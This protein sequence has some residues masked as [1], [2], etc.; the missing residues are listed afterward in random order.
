[1]DFFT[2]LSDYYLFGNGAREADSDDL[3]VLFDL[4]ADVYGRKSD[5]DLEDH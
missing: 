3:W 2:T 4:L 5:Y 1:M